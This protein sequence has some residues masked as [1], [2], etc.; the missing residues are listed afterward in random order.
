MEH[1]PTDGFSVQWDHCLYY[2]LIDFDVDLHLL[3]S[4]HGVSMH[5]KKNARD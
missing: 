5:V 4:V 1:S 3:F 2:V